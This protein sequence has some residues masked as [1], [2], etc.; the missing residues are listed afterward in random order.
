MTVALRAV[1]RSRDLGEESGSRFSRV[2][3]LCEA[4]LSQGQGIC[5]GLFL[6]AAWRSL[7]QSAALTAFLTDDK[8]KKPRGAVWRV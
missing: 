8:R 3:I 4:N 6:A 5:K 7:T 1:R 2:G